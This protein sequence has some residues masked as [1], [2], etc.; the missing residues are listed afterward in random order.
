MKKLIQKLLFGNP[1]KGEPIK[2][3]V[4]K[5]TTMPVE[6]VSLYDWMHGAWEQEKRDLNFQ[7]KK[8]Y[9]ENRKHST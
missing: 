5:K 6:N 3:K 1:V 8:A 2:K 7:I 4:R 9:N